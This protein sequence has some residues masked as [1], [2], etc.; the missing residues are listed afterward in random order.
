[1]SRKIA[2]L[3]ES[4]KKC[5]RLAGEGFTSKEI[6][7]KTAL[8]PLTVDQ[9]LRRATLALE[10][11][12]R[13]AAARKL[14]RIEAKGQFKKTEFKSAA[15][16]PAPLPAEVSSNPGTADGSPLFLGF[17]PLGGR[18]NTLSPIRRTGAIAQIGLVS[19]SALIALVL[20]IRAALNTFPS[21]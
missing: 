21:G 7:Q 16:A 6:A 5:L 3:N 14:A 15:L 8:S 1:M 17:P 12:N 9:Y 20:I 4:Q 2:E 19:A 13:R 11:P 10:A 18:P